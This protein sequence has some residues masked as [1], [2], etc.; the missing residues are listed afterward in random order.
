MAYTSSL[1]KKVFAA[2]IEVAT[3]DSLSLVLPYGRKRRP[4][5]RPRGCC[6]Y[7]DDPPVA[8]CR[9]PIRFLGAQMSCSSL[10]W[11]GTKREAL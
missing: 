1:A 6:G 4:D 5:A 7:R 3:R 11:L 2:E 9:E 10:R 8:G